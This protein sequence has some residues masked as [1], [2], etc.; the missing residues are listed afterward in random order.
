MS[1]YIK[2]KVTFVQKR[3]TFTGAA[4]RR[5]LRQGENT[6]LSWA[7][8]S[9]LTWWIILNPFH[10]SGGAG[11]DPW[12]GRTTVDQYICPVVI[13]YYGAVSPSLTQLSN[14]TKPCH[15]TSSFS[16]I[17]FA[18]RNLFLSQEFWV[19]CDDL[20]HWALHNSISSSSQLVLPTVVPDFGSY[21]MRLLP[22][23]YPV[24]AQFQNL[25]T[26]FVLP[27]V[28]CMKMWNMWNKDGGRVW[29]LIQTKDKLDSYVMLS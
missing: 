26:R 17:A 9:T 29:E 18:R 13:I 22:V 11:L 1:L 3:E 16:P 23:C 20:P 5:E 27:I 8:V 25:F 28:F 21:G 12:S 24:C 6:Q 4:S 2:K 19:K 15:V 10:F 7:S 14:L